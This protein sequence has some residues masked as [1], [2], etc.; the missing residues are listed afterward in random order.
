MY[1]GDS[2]P[3]DRSN[4][5]EEMIHHLDTGEALHPTLDLDFN[6]EVMAILDAGLRSAASGEM[7][8]VDNGVWRL[9]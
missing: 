8:R 7:E 9:G 6:L 2:L 1:E 3:A 4:I 5:A